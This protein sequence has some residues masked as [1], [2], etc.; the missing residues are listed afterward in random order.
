MAFLKDRK[1]IVGFFQL[2]SFFS[3]PGVIYADRVVVQS[4]KMRQIYIKVMMDFT[5][6]HVISENGLKEDGRLD[7][8]KIRAKK[9][10]NTCHII[11]F[12]IWI[13]YKNDIWFSFLK[14]I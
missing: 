13:M 7:N 10:M 8:T 2:P 6:D 12:I 11:T 9:R 4:E 1:R 14:R 3:L 5:T